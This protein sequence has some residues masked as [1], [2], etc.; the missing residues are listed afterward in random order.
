MKTLLVLAFIL[1]LAV[2]ADAQQAPVPNQEIIQ[3]L[4]AQRDNNAN[5]HA[6]SMATITKLQ[7]EIE[8]LKAKL[9]KAEKKE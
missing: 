9:A 4:Q 8:D 3:A 5:M 2:T 7:A 6:Q 1:A